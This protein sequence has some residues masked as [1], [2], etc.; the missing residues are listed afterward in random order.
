MKDKKAAARTEA[1]KELKVNERK[2]SKTLMDAGWTVIPG[3]IIERQR[4]LGLDAL[5]MNILLHLANHWW[6]HDNKPHPSKKRIAEAMQVTPRTVQRH[7]AALEAAGFIRREQRRIPGHGSKTNRYHFDG[8]IKAARPFA[9][10]KLEEKARHEGE[11][12]ERTR[13]RRPR[14][15]LVKNDDDGDDNAA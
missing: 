1:A 7:I 13:R 3:V 5:D 11:S 8:L 9:L 14:L 4:A 6:T 2:W 12:K 15:Q 10:E